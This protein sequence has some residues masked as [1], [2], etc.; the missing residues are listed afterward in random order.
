MH[1]AT[2]S[3]PSPSRRS[4][5]LASS[6]FVPMPSVD[7]IRTGS[8]YPGGIEMPA[9]KTAEASRDAGVPR[10]GHS[11]LDSGDELFGC[12]EIHSGF[13]VRGHHDRSSWYLSPVVG[14][15]VGY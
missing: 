7:I 15:S 12:V 14:I 6:A 3:Q 11:R 9:A 4:A 13:P 10:L 1:M 8:A 5:C 2:R